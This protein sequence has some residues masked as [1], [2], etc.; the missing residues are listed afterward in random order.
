MRCRVVTE[1]AWH[2]MFAHTMLIR[3]Q[4]EELDGHQPEFTILHAPGLKVRRR[5]AR[6]QQGARGRCCSCSRADARLAFP[7]TGRP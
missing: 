2:A 7:L 1:T 5:G 4:G 3:P 6:G